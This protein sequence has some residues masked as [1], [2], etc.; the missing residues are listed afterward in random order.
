MSCEGGHV[1]TLQIQTTSV[2]NQSSVYCNLIIFIDCVDDSDRASW[3]VRVILTDLC[4]V[5]QRSLESTDKIPDTALKEVAM[6]TNFTFN[7]STLALLPHFQTVSRK[8]QTWD[9][10]KEFIHTV[11]ESGNH[12]V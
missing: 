11:K 5:R 4:A 8:R 2:N 9:L 10:H 7:L 12:F 3:N 1:L 6:T